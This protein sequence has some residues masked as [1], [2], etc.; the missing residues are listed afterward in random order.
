SLK[1]DSLSFIK[2]GFS[3]VT[4]TFIS[5][6]KFN[7]RDSPSF[8]KGTRINFTVDPSS[9]EILACQAAQSIG[10]SSGGTF[11]IVDSTVDKSMDGLT[12]N[13]ACDLNNKKCSHVLSQNFA[14]IVYGQDSLANLCQINYNS[15]ANDIKSGTMLSNIHSCDAKVGT[16]ETY[17]L[18]QKTSG[19]TCKGMFRAICY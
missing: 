13:E 8:P 15:K 19:V 18:K 3:T 6:F 9:F 2:E 11:S 14:S 16:Y 7:L 10:G 1:K 17:L 5:T 12:G 4:L